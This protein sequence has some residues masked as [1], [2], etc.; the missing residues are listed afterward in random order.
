ML[1]DRIENVLRVAAVEHDARA[2]M[3]KV[4]QH[5]AVRSSGMKQ[6]ID[7]GRAV[8]F[9]LV[10]RSGKRLRVQH[11]IAMSE[12]RALREAGGAGGV[13]DDV[14]VVG[15]QLARWRRFAYGG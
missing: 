8:A 1:R 4:R 12:C 11:V 13:E 5:D 14:G 3:Q 9:A 6:W 2:A 10:R 7:D 15:A